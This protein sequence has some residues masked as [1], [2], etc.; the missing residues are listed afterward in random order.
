MLRGMG[1]HERWRTLQARLASVTRRSQAE[2][3]LAK[4]IQHH[5]DERT[6]LHVRRGL[7]LADARRLAL[8]EL[9]GVEQTKERVRDERRIPIVETVIRDVR[10]ALRV[11]RRNPGFT[12]AA[13]LTLALG[14]GANTAIF[15][16]V[17]AILLRPLPYTDPER[18]VSVTGTYPR[19]A[20][21]AMRREI[22]TMDVAT[23][24]EGHN[25]NLTAIGEPV[26]LASTL[27]SA[28]LFSVLGTRAALGRT[29][30]PGEDLPGRERL[31]VL[32]HGVWTRTFASDPRIIGRTIVL[33]G[34][35]HEI[36][37]VMPADFR[38]PSTK[39][40]VW[41][42]LS[43]D[44]TQ[45][46]TYWASDFM[47]VVARL[48]RGV[49]IEQ[50]GGDA[51][52]FQP[53]VAKMFPWTMP[54]SWNAD[55]TAVPLR[56]GM[57]GDLRA[58]LVVLLGIV[59]LVLV[60][61]CANVANLTIARGATREREIG[62]RT[63]LG[64]ARVRIAG[65]LL[66]ESLVLSVLGGVAGLLV[67]AQG[68]AVLRRVLPP[69]T[70]R[71]LEAT[72]D[73]R[74]LAFT[75]VLSLATG[76]LF[77]LAPAFQSARGSGSASA[78]SSTRGVALLVTRNL[79][80]GLV[81]G[82]VGLAVMLVV[83]AGLLVRSLWTLTHVHTGFR[84]EQVVTARITPSPQFCGDVA[85]CL[86]FYQQ[87]VDDMRRAPGV[88][89]AA[90]ANTPPLTGRVAKRSVV[91]AGLPPTASAPLFWL[92]AVTADYFRVMSIPIMRGRAFTDGDL[93][94]NLPVAIVPATT[95]ER[96]WPGEDAVGRQVRFVGEQTS[97]TI[98]GIAADVRAF[99]LK[100][101]VPAYMQGALYVPYNARAT[102]EDGR[103]P[104]DMTI[105]V[106]AAAD[107]ATVGALLR[108]SIATLS[109][110]VPIGEIR[111]LDANVAEAV[112][113]PASLT[114]LVVAFAG[115]ALILGS[116]GIYGVLSFLV[117][118]R[119][120]EIGIRLAL[121]ATRRHVF[122]SVMR[123]GLLFGASG[124][125]LGLGAASLLSRVLARE[126]YGVNPIDPLTYTSVAIG[127]AAVTLLACSIPTYRATRVDP[128]IALRQE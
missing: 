16:L 2:R 25:V 92:N 24:A 82:E 88:R 35:S 121:G 105:A 49:T 3:E 107:P 42:P 54:K 72:L 98:V 34:M 74:V 93:T 58:R 79:R 83:A 11:L 125:L 127:M 63:A 117:S 21:A 103:V 57:V 85:R 115:L 96:F 94:G 62:V 68:L 114:L 120:R 67:A 95:A 89:A 126:L 31:V 86:S 70:P 84:S 39:T 32:S 111:A 45:T 119:T 60:I 6:Q 37:G 1:I 56:D 116:V 44:P 108:H 78:G 13:V 99:D 55:V 91:I 9:G 27:V 64:A 29:F 109:Q 12:L 101:D 8:S 48:K 118:K 30:E 112:S 87:V 128:L 100:N 104:A 4:E 23:Y 106:T 38:F 81:I 61:A 26:R 71:L 18:L 20:F 122:W 124:I 41:M 46:A 77:G 113:S 66:T 102:L 17:D 43:F 52:A 90:L 76:L 40:D 73:W 80:R 51:R 33:D 123:E 10:Y 97:R 14:I 69:D 75:G 19:G 110:E 36:V 47:P 22:R 65:Q 7:P 5:V 59:A 50:A 53:R 15:S 28:E